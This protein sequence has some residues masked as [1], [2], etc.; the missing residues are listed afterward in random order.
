MA[1]IG[2]K[3]NRD[4]SGLG[5]AELFS[6][7]MTSGVDD[8]IAVAKLKSSLATASR[9]CLLSVSSTGAGTPD[10]AQTPHQP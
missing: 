9:T 6:K 10:A 7:A 4:N 1:T 5:I 2:L 8:A 3:I